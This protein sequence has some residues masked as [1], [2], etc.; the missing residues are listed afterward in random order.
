MLAR[1]EPY[2]LRDLDGTPASPAQARQIIAD[3]YAITDQ[4]RRRRRS[5]K[6][7]R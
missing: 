3:R 2:V 6:A 5:R 1:G 7:T 4:A